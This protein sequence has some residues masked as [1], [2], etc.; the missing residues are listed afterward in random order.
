MVVEANGS[1]RCR[2]GKEEWLAKIVVVAGGVVVGRESIEAV[3]AVKEVVAVRSAQW[4]E[5]FGCGGK[6]G[7]LW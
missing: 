4:C 5:L 1:C 3:G 2:S 6:C 7:L